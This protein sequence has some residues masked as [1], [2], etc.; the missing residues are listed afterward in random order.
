[1]RTNIPS[2]VVI[3]YVQVAPNDRDTFIKVLQ[4]HPARPQEGWLHRLFLR[5][6]CPQPERGTNERGLAGSGSSRHASR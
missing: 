1:M 5:G 6:R 3:G 4:P 2:V